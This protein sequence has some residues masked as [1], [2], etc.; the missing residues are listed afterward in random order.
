MYSSD[1]K[2]IVVNSQCVR[3]CSEKI[4]FHLTMC[5]QSSHLVPKN[6]PSSN[7]NDSI[8]AEI[9]LNVKYYLI[10]KYFIVSIFGESRV[11]GFAIS[12]HLSLP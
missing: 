12:M 7:R 5:V 11:V 2:Q 1:W 4:N 3:N 9:R 6:G 10:I 8:D